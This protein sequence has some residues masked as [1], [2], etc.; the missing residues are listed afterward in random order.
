MIFPPRTVYHHIEFAGDFDKSNEQW[1]PF[2]N[3]AIDDSRRLG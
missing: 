1:V 2:V 3:S